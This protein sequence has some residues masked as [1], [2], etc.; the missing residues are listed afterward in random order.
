MT[1][2]PKFE[3]TRE[4]FKKTL[5]SDNR[6]SKTGRLLDSLWQ[7]VIAWRIGFFFA[8]YDF[9]FILGFLIY[10]P[11]YIWRKKINIPA[12]REK[13]G[14]IRK[15]SDTETIWIHTVSVGEVNLI[16]NLTK[17][18]KELYNYPIVISTTTL[19]GNETAK[20]RY[21]SLA[22]IIFFPLDVSFLIKKTLKIIN[23]KIFIAVETEIWPNLYYRLNQKG[24]PIVIVNGRV[25]DKA[26]TKYLMIKPFIKS[27][28]NK[29]SHIGVQ[30]IEYK[31]R[32]MA[33]GAHKNKVSVSG[34]MKF[35]NLL[36]D[37]NNLK[38]IKTEYMPI[39]KKGNNL[40]LIAASTHPPEEE[41]IIDIYKSISSLIK[42]IT[43]LVAPRHPERVPAIE[44]IILSRNFNPVRIS[45]A[46]KYP[47]GK[48][49]IFIIDTVG[50]LLYFYNISDIC[51]VGGSLS[52]DGGHNI[53]EPIY[54]LKPTVFGPNMNNFRDIEEV[55]LKRKAAIK[56]NNARKLKETL[57]TLLKDETSRDTLRNKCFKVFENE[58]KSLDKNLEII[59]RYLK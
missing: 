28:I 41:I 26:F 32:F 54:F 12:F 46:L 30:N 18:L 7:R 42:D 47:E 45:N 33:L 13:L 17:R 50:E 14:F 5:E 52:K 24:I 10:L 15:I 23:P 38:K 55:V 48:D 21:N 43:L 39:L 59:S 20:K 56:V 27:V 37:Q 40:L 34:N 16:G 57:F 1:K 6:G 35:E 19:T 22:R 29:C 51:F 44:N 36:I 9:I 11:V 4:T 58:K 49:N 8:V 25:S 53:L 2:K 3:N 31:N